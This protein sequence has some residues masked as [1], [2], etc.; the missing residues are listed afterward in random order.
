[1]PASVSYSKEN[2]TKFDGIFCLMSKKYKVPKLILKAM[3]IQE[4]ALLPDAYRME[5]DFW[6]TYLDG[7]EEWGAEERTVVS[8]S[9][10]LMQL[11]YVVA[12][13]LGFK[14]GRSGEELCDPVVNIELGAKKLRLILDTMYKY[15]TPDRNFDMLPIKMAIAKYNGGGG[16]GPDKEGNLRK[17]PE[18]H[19]DKVM[20]IWTELREEETECDADQV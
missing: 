13:E 6:E 18:K 11:M 20:K 12:V 19:A 7:T 3:A 10:G 9:W 14:K 15:K 16:A 8:A 2:A 4:S 17:R 5:E 1:M